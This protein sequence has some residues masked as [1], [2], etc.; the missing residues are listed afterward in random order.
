MDD[1]RLPERS[2][3]RAIVVLAEGARRDLSRAT[4][5]KQW[6]S[7]V[8]SWSR[9]LKQWRFALAGV[10]VSTLIACGGETEAGT[11]SQEAA[12]TT[13]KA[14]SASM[15]NFLEARDRKSVV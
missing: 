8:C 12:A 1:G 3:G 4:A 7:D 14:S 2:R 15:Q 5:L 11:D 6:W 9:M 10:L 13:A